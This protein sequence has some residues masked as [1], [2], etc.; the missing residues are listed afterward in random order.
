MSSLLVVSTE[1]S[2]LTPLVLK[3]HTYAVHKKCYGVWFYLVVFIDLH[4]KSQNNYRIPCD[5]RVKRIYFVI[6]HSW[7]HAN[8]KEL[9][10]RVPALVVICLSLTCACATCAN[11]PPLLTSTV[12]YKSAASE[13]TTSRNSNLGFSFFRYFYIVLAAKILNDL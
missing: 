8:W 4:C 3:S 9:L 13:C 10:A 12:V 6:T 7:T 1:Q 11:P 5:G 2:T